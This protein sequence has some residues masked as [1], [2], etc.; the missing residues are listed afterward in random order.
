LDDKAAIRRAVLTRRDELPSSL[1][2]AHD[3]SIHR[4]LFS[5]PEFSAATAI[6]LFASFRSEVST[7]TIIP[8]ALAAGKRVIVPRVDRSMKELILFE[9]SGGH[10]LTA[11]YMGIPEPE[12]SVAER[13]DDCPLDLVIMPGAAFDTRGNRIGY[14]GGYYDRLIPRLA[15]APLRI[16]LAYEAQIVAS[17]PAEPHDISV[18]VIVTES[19]II[20]CRATDISTLP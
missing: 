19:R 13:A 4:L 7:E 20:D 6:L 5:L 14:G 2:A 12:E 11:G 9:I 10:Q 17:V 16:A 8:S 3:A 18:Q 1:R 15:G